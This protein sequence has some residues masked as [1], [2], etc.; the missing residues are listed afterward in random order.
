MVSGRPEL[1]EYGPRYSRYVEPVPEDGIRTAFVQQ[2]ERTE[3]R[4]KAIPDSLVDR[5]YAPGKWTT[6]EVVGHILDTERIYGFRL[7]TF[8]RGDAAALVRADQELY[9]RNGDFGRRPLR[10][11]L[12]EFSQVRRSHIALVEHLP[13]E[14]WARSGTVSGV[15]VSVRAMAFLM[16]GHE[17]HHLRILEEKSLPGDI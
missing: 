2:L 11:W 5:R 15:T 12:E 7:L 4:L 17:R 9:V 10:E 3:T 6:R 8:A 1:S 13:S 14:A 16:L